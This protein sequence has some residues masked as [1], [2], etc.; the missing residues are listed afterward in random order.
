MKVEDYPIFMTVLEMCEIL[1]VSRDKGY[2]LIRSKEVPATRIG[3]K[4]VIPRDLLI[5]KY[6]TSAAQNVA[7]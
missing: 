5:E 4:I 2:Q 1:G 6:F 7:G 3:K